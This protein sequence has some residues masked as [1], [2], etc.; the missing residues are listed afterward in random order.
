[1]RASVSDYVHLVKGVE[2][3]VT[4]DKFTVAERLMKM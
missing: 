1:M 2:V 3:V 4:Q